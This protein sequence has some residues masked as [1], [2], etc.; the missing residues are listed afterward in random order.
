MQSSRCKHQATH[1]WPGKGRM[2]RLVAKAHKPAKLHTRTTLGSRATGPGLPQCFLHFPGVSCTFLVV[3]LWGGGGRGDKNAI[4]IA[5]MHI[6]LVFTACTLHKDVQQDTLSQ[7]SMLF[8]TMPKA[9][10]FTAFVLLV[11]YCTRMWNK[12]SCHKLPCL[13]RPCQKH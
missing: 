10:V 4:H 3:R 13:W 9:P 2:I 12:Q 11:P 1:C 8:A 5:S 7:A 6:T